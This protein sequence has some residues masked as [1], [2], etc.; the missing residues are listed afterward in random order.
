MAAPAQGQE[1]EVRYTGVS[2]TGVSYTGVSYTGVS[3]TGVSYTGVSYTGKQDSATLD[4]TGHT[5]ADMLLENMLHPKQQTYCMLLS[6]MAGAISC[7]PPCG[8]LSHST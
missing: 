2:Y 4:V 7:V 1:T 3:Y 5:A 8:Y 6:T